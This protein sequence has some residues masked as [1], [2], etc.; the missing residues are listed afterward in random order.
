[1]GS[2][3]V[4]PFNIHHRKAGRINRFNRLSKGEVTDTDKELRRLLEVKEDLE[5][6]DK[7]LSIYGRRKAYL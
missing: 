7:H 4:S 5:D 2:D 3:T 1:M 6:I